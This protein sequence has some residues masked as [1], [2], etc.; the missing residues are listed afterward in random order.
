MRRKH[1]SIP[2]SL[3]KRVEESGLLLAGQA[4]RD[5]QRFE[6]HLTEC[7]ARQ[8]QPL[9]SAECTPCTNRGL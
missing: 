4:D 2:Q 5:E 7:I 9:G 6:E 8:V 1:T 3:A